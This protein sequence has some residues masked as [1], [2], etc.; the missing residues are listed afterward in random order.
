MY[1]L[2]RYIGFKQRVL[3]YIADRHYVTYILPL[4]RE[5][6][7]ILLFDTDIA[8]KHKVLVNIAV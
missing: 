3:V 7:L 2:D 4:N 1:L 8:V 6:S 5:L